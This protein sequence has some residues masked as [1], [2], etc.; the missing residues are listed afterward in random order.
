MKINELNAGETVDVVLRHAEETSFSVEIHAESD[1]LLQSSTHFEE[2]LLI[3]GDKQWPVL[4]DGT[5]QQA[6]LEDIISQNR[7]RLCSV[8][9]SIPVK[10]E[11]EK[12]IV[13]I[14][15]FSSL[16]ILPQNETININ[17][18]DVNFEELRKHFIKKINLTNQQILDWLHEHLVIRNN[19]KS[20][21][22]ISAG[23]A[24]EFE[25]LNA[26]S[27][28]I[29][30]HKIAINI[31][32]RDGAFWISKIIHSR[33]PRRG[34]PIL[35][36]QGIMGF[37]DA[38]VVTQYQKTGVTELDYIVKQSAGSYLNIWNQYNR[39]ERDILIERAREFGWLYYKE[40]EPLPDGGWRLH[41]SSEHSR[42][43]EQITLHEEVDFEIAQSLPDEFSELENDE[44]ADVD[45]ELG[46]KPL[47]QKMQPTLAVNC[48]AYDIDRS[49]IDVRPIFQDESDAPPRAGY[50]F[51]SMSGD[52]V[53]L[54][55]RQYAWNRISR[56]ENPIPGLGLLL[57]RSDK[58]VSRSF[59]KERINPKKLRFAF[60]TKPTEKQ[61]LAI[62]IAINT[63]DIA[64]I[65]GPPRHG[66]NSRNIGFK[67]V[68]S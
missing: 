34:Q 12:L 55:R 31:E 50:L 52:R 43:L 2:L 27:F 37:V 6:L 26:S 8:A 32:K 64:I 60:G 46:I 11:T 47:T 22:A 44:E 38:S 41:V 63:P 58:F 24:T 13:S 23:A 30:G 45:E 51:I 14:R 21:I 19:E 28:R 54:N 61:E 10:G 36:I 5:S 7:P 66:K 49:F 33:S 9:Q 35:L 25:N 59:P 65:Q 18:T 20:L 40:R 57:E 15:S 17:L 53:R 67:Q 56:S 1:A 62:D 39:L 16:H 4:A 48:V 3:I 42:K 29:F 68:N